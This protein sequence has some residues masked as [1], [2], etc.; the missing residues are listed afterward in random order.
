MPPER[1]LVTGGSGFIGRN[2]VESLSPCYDVLA[3]TH[4]ELELTDS[5]A[6]R[7]YLHDRRPDVIVHGAVRP[8]HR[9]AKDISAVAEANRRMFLNL[10][11]DPEFCP[12][13]VFLSSG[14]V[15]DQ[16]Q[17]TPKITEA[18]FGRHLPADDN[19]RSK[20]EA[21]RFIESAAHVVELRPFGVYGPHEDYSIRFISNAVC[22]ALLGLP[23]T[24]RQ[25]R[26]FDY[27]WVG[28][29]VRVIEHFI[30]RPRAELAHAA[31]NV[32]PDE[33][34]SLL[35]IANLVVELS[36]ADVPV[37]VG[38]PG[39]GMEY[40]GDNARLREELGDFA[41]TSLR[42]GITMLRDWYADRLDT[43]DRGVLEVDL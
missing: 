21:A 13:M 2:L 33:S 34:S 27:V 19:G 5:D 11:G 6:V 15:Y 37:L 26:R 32:T 23:V 40:S 31:Y 25:D 1:V 4:A 35:D 12:R 14:A 16:Q 9:A 38:A 3:P 29:L 17:C 8:S 22:K 24:L 28:D 39:I 10:A 7:A 18:C 20:Y 43:L 30:L 41:F 36:G 42:D